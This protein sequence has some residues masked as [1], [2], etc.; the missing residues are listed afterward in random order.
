MKIINLTQHKAT[1]EQVAQ[2][3]MDLTAEGRAYVTTLLTFDTLP[4]RGEL[5]E[6]ADELAAYVEVL[7]ILPDGGK[8]L[9]GGA[10]FFMSALEKALISIGYKPVYA[11]SHRES[12]EVMDGDTV[13][14][15]TVFR[16][17]GLVEVL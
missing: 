10:P 1:P 7:S 11:F 15:T 12:V 14:K 6:R 8:V 13:E 17:S 5:E 4:S 2:G 16:H 9:I 3:V